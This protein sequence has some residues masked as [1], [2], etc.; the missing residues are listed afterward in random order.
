MMKDKQYISLTALPLVV[1]ITMLV[2][3][4]IRVFVPMGILP[5]LDIPNMVLLSLIALVLSHYI[6][7]TQAFALLP[8]L[9]LA[10][11]SFG[12]LPLAAGLAAPMAALKLALV[13]GVVY[14]VTAWV[15]GE[16]I[17]WLST[18]IGGKA[19][20]VFG[21]LGLFLAVQCFCSM[22]L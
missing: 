12:L 5:R 21:A 3:A 6:G 22:I 19:A 14:T 16:M 11:L 17:D 13:G 7:K 18:G 20:P 4:L 10:V 8:S 9:I 1:G 15:F 2:C